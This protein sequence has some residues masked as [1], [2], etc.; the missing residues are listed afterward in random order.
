M[1]G[2]MTSDDFN[3]SALYCIVSPTS[4]TTLHRPH[5]AQH[6]V[7]TIL[8]VFFITIEN[9]CWSYTEIR[10]SFPHIDELED[11]HSGFCWSVR[12]VQMSSVRQLMLLFPS[13]ACVHVLLSI[14]NT[15]EHSSPS[16]VFSSNVKR[17]EVR[18]S[19]MLHINFILL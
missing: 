16:A 3:M 18:I 15:I 19:R 5:P 8:N 14:L 13:C 9:S 7:I 17:S 4:L 10:R 11:E 1:T 12:L 6:W 2:N